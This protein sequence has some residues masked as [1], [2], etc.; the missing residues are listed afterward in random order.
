MEGMQRMKNGKAIGPDDIPSGGMEM[1]RIE[2]TEVPDETA[3]Q[4]D[5]K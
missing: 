2:C 4:N 5:G 3:Q 1:S